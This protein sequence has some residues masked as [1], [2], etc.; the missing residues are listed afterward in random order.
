V[1]YGAMERNF[2]A[3]YILRH[4][5]EM[6]WARVAALG[7]EVKYDIVNAFLSQF[8]YVADYRLC[9]DLIGA[10]GTRLGIDGRAM[11]KNT[12]AQ[13][14]RHVRWESLELGDLSP[15]TIARIESE[16]LIDQRLWE[17]W[18]DARND[19]AHVRPRALGSSRA[20]SVVTDEAVRLLNQIARR[21]QRRWGP[22]GGP[23]IP[24]PAPSAEG[25][26]AVLV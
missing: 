13:W 12:Q 20:T 10:I 22:V 18:R 5:L 1:A 17:T 26:S 3:H 6:S 4:F 19:V 7:D 21:V 16:N 2:I 23:E 14:E 9:D 15:G 11:P 8:W 24:A 25:S